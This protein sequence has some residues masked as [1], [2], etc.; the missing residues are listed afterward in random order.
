MTLEERFDIAAE[1]MQRMSALAQNLDRLLPV[2]AGCLQH[3]Q[4]GPECAACDT[5]PFTEAV[6][7]APEGKS[8]PAEYA[9]TQ[10][11][12]MMD[13]MRQLRAMLQRT[14]QSVPIIGVAD[15]TR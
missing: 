7:H 14:C 3:I 13:D 10:L 2:Y 8:S 12:G 5:C 1:H 4:D 15:C 11:Q 9:L 6:R